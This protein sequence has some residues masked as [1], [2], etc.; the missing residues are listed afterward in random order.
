MAMNNVAKR[1]NG[2]IKF[3]GAT[4]LSAL[5]TM[6]ALAQVG[7]VT[8][9]ADKA[10]KESAASQDR[11]D[12]VD[13]DTGDIV[14][15]YRQ[16]L[17]ELEGLQRFNKQLQELVDN[18]KQEVVSL[19]AQIEEATGLDREIYPF[20]EEML[21]AIE[22]FINLDTPFLLDKRLKDVATVRNAM[23]NAD[24]SV[25][26][27]FRLIMQLYTRENEYGSKISTYTGRFE[28]G[29]KVIDEVTYL[30]VGRVIFV[31]LTKDENEAGVWNKETRSWDKL[32]GSY[33][34]GIKQARRIADETAPPNLMIL[35]V[36]AA[37]NAQ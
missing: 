4:A 33:I 11:I 5:M 29:D 22:E 31:Y 23:S 28:S 19:N 10:A 12:T 8:G 32:P 18:Q 30:Q 9:E 34:A 14:A 24:V 16:K 13:N 17:D 26:E 27:K 3:L 36:Q 20:M 21:V 15:K 6:P 2:L 1:P 7:G 25:A 35:P 37:E